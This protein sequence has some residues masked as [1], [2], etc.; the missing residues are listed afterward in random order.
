MLSPVEARE[1]VH[2]LVLRELAARHHGG[3]FILKGGA[4][5]RLFLGSARYSEDMDL[6]GEPGE[7]AAFRTTIRGVFSDRAL[8]QQLRS[9]GVRHLDPGDGPNKDTATVFR[10]KFG[11][12]MP[13]EIRYPTKIE[14]SY[15]QR[16]AADE[17]VFDTPSGEIV[18]RYLVG[19]GESVTLAHYS[20]TAAARQKIAALVG[21]SVVQARDIFDL[22]VLSAGPGSD[23]LDLMTLHRSTG[24]DD[25]ATATDR[26]LEVSFD[27]YCGQVL[28]FIGD[29]ARA[30]LEEESAWDEIR[31]SVLSLIED[32]AEL[33]SQ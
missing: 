24:P 13:G 30:G 31:L 21:R 28:E 5:L 12:V 1:A 14:I 17:V 3:S 19:E 15:R 32:I 6:D 22:F 10:Y 20:R 26:V 16:N 8:H 9:L 4:N 29:E 11:I 18:S 7:A 23:E 33:G 25:L 27:A 2:V